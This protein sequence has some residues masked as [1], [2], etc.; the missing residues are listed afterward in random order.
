MKQP[1]F[2]RHNYLIHEAKFQV[3]NFFKA[4]K[5]DVAVS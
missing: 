4:K 3:Y 1:V 2:R 5:I